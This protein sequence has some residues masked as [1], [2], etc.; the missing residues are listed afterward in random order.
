MLE[1]WLGMKFEETDWYKRKSCQGKIQLKSC[2][3]AILRNQKT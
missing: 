3:Y 2:V 1:M